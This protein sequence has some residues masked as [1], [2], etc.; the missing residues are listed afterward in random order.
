MIA[1]G[2]GCREGTV[3]EFRIDMYILLYLKWITNKVIYVC[4]HCI[5]QGILLN[6]MCQ[7]RWEGSF[8]ENGYMYMF[9]RVSLLST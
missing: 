7:P 9:G 5:A 3:R 2:E 8:G 4:N 1:S 6:V